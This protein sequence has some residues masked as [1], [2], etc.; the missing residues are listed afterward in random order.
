MDNNEKEKKTADSSGTKRWILIAAAIVLSVAMAYFLPIV[1]A[2]NYVSAALPVDAGS[3]KTLINQKVSGVLT[4][5][6]TVTKIYLRGSL[7]GILHD[8]SLLSETLES[9]YERQ[10]AEKFPDS[11]IGLGE[12]VYVVE[13]M[14]YYDYENIDE[15]LMNYL[16]DNSLFSVKAH[17]ISFSNGA[18]IYVKD[19]D[20]FQKVREQFIL[21]F[22]DENTY[23]TLQ[24]HQAVTPLN[25]YGEQDIDLKVRETMSVSEGLAP[26]E[27]ILTT[28][29]EILKF[30]SYGYDTIEKEYYT[31]VV[32]DTVAGVVAQVGDNL[33]ARQLI[34]LNP[35][36]LISED[37][38]IAPGTKLNITYF[39]SPISVEVTKERLAEELVYPEATKTVYDNTRYVGDRVVE[40][41]EVIG[42]KNI[43]YHDT[44]VNGI[45][46]GGE[47]VSEV[48][49]VQPVQRVVRVGTKTYGGG[50]IDEYI[51]G[52]GSFWWPVKNPIVSCNWG[53]YP[54]HIGVDIQDRY[55]N[56][57]HVY[58]SDGGTVVVNNY[59]SINGYYYVIDHHNGYFT[60]YGHMRTPGWYAVGTEVEQ[61]QAIGDIGMTGRATGPH[62]HFMISI[63]GIPFYG[64]KIVNA[65]PYL[66]GC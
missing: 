1:R 44:Y 65:C 45:L 22:V 40:T 19:L 21:N 3:E 18:V 36:V 54:G 61:G 35:E 38:L 8:D 12:D 59:T 37:Q 32:G 24:N 60:Y 9:V 47:I 50:P 63:G 58:A 66:P 39:Q 29:E 26:E 2:K 42:K 13:Q 4:T 55:N 20:M 53:C 10:Y 43:R 27:K 49:T 15:Q 11:A 7:I 23:R 34:T 52:Q 51:T 17:K 6:E 5:P 57:G 33:S 16:A 46:T 64:G 56:W 31:T 48:M 28:E 30:F 41:E 62:V 25:T 14:T